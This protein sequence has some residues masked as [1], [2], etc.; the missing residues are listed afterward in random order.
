MADGDISISPMDS[1]GK[2]ISS[3]GN[4]TGG[5]EGPEVSRCSAECGSQN[6]NDAKWSRRHQ[7]GL[8]KILY[9]I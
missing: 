4:Y 3:R 9:L 1:E 5:C 2:V 6:T 8:L 7:E